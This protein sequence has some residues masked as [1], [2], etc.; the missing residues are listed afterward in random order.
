MKLNSLLLY[1]V[2]QEAKNR[3]KKLFSNGESCTSFNQSETYDEYCDKCKSKTYAKKC[4]DNAYNGTCV[5]YW[6]SFYL[7]EKI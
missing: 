1:N 5:I 6:L 3:S 4:I 7:S 2:C